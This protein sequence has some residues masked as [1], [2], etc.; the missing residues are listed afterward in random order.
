[1]NNADGLDD[2][3]RVL[4]ADDARVIVDLLKLAVANRAGPRAKE[5]LSTLLVALSKASLPVRCRSIGC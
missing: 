3:T 2:F 1:V 4:S 5:I